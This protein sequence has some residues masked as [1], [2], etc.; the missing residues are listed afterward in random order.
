MSEFMEPHT[1]MCLAGQ[2]SLEMTANG[3]ASYGRGRCRALRAS[4]P[5]L[6]YV[7]GKVLGWLLEL[8]TAIG[9]AG[10]GVTLWTLSTDTPIIH[11]PPIIVGA[12]LVGLGAI[13]AFLS[14]ATRLGFTVK[15]PAVV[16]GPLHRYRELPQFVRQVVSFLIAGWSLALLLTVIAVRLRWIYQLDPAWI[17]AVFVGALL[18]TEAVV[19]VAYTD[20]LQDRIR[21]L[22]KRPEVA[23]EEAKVSRIADLR[24]QI[25]GVAGALYK[26]ARPNIDGSTRWDHVEP[27]NQLLY[28]LIGQGEDVNAFVVPYAWKQGELVDDHLLITRLEG[29]LVYLK[30]KGLPSAD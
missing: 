17:F 16:E 1:T 29:L 19:F 18:A 23:A 9:V 3:L 15:T 11:R 10:G 13:I 5:L 30:R 8:A 24:E 14:S 26:Y 7:R 25:Y 27:L 6:S 21:R 20:E 12:A 28:K 2:R 22:S 4:T